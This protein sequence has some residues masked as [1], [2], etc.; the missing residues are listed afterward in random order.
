MESAIHDCKVPY[1]GRVLIVARA[2]WFLPSNAS[3]LLSMEVT[4]PIPHACTLIFFGARCSHLVS[5]ALHPYVPEHAPTQVRSA[6]ARRIEEIESALIR[7]G[8]LSLGFEVLFALHSLLRILLMTGPWERASQLP[9]TFIKG[10][11]AQEFHVIED[12][13]LIQVRDVAAIDPGKHCFS[14]FMVGG[15][16][17]SAKRNYS[18]SRRIPISSSTCAFGNRRGVHPSC[19]WRWMVAVRTKSILY[20]VVSM[21]PRVAHSSYETTA[22]WHRRDQ[23]G[24]SVDTPVAC[25][26]PFRFYYMPPF[27]M[28]GVQSV[29]SGSLGASARR[30]ARPSSGLQRSGSEGVAAATFW[31]DQRA[32]EAPSRAHCATRVSVSC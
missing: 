20:R 24:C 12:Y 22:T 13:P 15:C 31:H 8:T 18:S 11:R 32:V 21:W 30:R 28:K 1:L 23:D 27:S 25:A 19:C 4:A 3:K 7:H 6:M 2:I 14:M 10:L 17:N 5:R 9:R 26:V 29:T 16:G